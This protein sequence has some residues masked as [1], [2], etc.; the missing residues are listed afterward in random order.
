MKIKNIVES[1][2]GEKFNSCLLN[3]YH[4]GDD[5]MAWHS[6]SEKELKKHGMI[7]SISFG[8]R[9][10]FCFKHKET[11]EKYSLMLEH[12]SALLMSKETQDHWLHQLPK[13]KKSDSIR[14]N[15]TFRQIKA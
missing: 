15:L 12:G 9:R 8:A 7:A 11:K 6:D 13:T 2:S 10:K 5:G 1:Y 4:D 3:L 14:I